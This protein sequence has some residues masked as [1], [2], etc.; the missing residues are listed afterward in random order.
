MRLL[1]LS[2]ARIPGEKANT[3][4]VLQMCDAFSAVGMKVTLLH[5][6]RV[7]TPEMRQIKDIKGYYK[8]HNHFPFE[9]LPT[10]DLLYL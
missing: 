8:L 10:I 9:E 2:T 4:Q 6:K 7:N 5:P 1:Y 3:Y